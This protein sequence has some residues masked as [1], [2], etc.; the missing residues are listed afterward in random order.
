MKQRAI[1][2]LVPLIKDLIYG[3]KIKCIVRMNYGKFETHY[4]TVGDNN[5][6]EVFSNDKDNEEYVHNPKLMGKPTYDEDGRL[7]SQWRWGQPFAFFLS[8]KLESDEM[9]NRVY[10]ML[11]DKTNQTLSTGILI[12]MNKTHGKK[13]GLLEDPVIMAMILVVILVAANLVIDYLSFSKLGVDLL[14]R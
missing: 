3:K 10:E 13:K 2:D 1:I 14:A 4:Y 11:D 7:I 9:L 8:H 6:L 5:V 12:G